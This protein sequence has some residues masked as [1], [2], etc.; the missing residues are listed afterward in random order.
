MQRKYGFIKQNAI[1]GR[2]NMNSTVLKINKQKS[3]NI[4]QPRKFPKEEMGPE[5]FRKLHFRILP[6][7][8]ISLIRGLYWSEVGGRGGKWH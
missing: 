6:E 5:K 2:R 7:H 8:S 1:L 3:G 4:S